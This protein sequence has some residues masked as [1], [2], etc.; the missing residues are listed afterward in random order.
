[1]NAQYSA[2]F[3]AYY[4]IGTKQKKKNERFLL[5]LEDKCVRIPKYNSV[6]Q[7][8]INYFE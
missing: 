5:L 8:A 6:K 1:M 4:K 7:D 2:L 3:L